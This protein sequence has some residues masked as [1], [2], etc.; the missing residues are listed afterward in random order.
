MSR[1]LKGYYQNVNRVGNLHE[2][3]SP[4]IFIYSF[5]F[6]MLSIVSTMN[7]YSFCNM[8]QIINVILRNACS[9]MN[10]QNN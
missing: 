1:K 6:S 10:F 4:V 3:N 5:C 7:T 9:R 8:K 2:K